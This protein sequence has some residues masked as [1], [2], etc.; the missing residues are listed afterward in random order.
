MQDLFRK[1]WVEIFI[2]VYVKHKGFNLNA[3]MIIFKSIL[4]YEILGVEEIFQWNCFGQDFSKAYMY[5]T[6]EEKSARV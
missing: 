4:N 2:F 1:I 3:T 5:V 6:I